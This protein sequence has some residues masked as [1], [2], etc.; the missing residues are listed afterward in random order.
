MAELLLHAED[1]DKQFGITHAVNHVTLDFYK[2]EIHALIGENGSGKSTFTS[3][4]T[5]IYTKEHGQ[6]FLEGQEIHPLNQVDANRK[7]V[8][9]IVQEVGTL[10]GLTVAENI[11]LGKEDDFI[12]N[13]I[14][15]T[16]AMNRKA[17]ELLD[18]YGFTNID[19][20]AVI[21]TYNFEE[22]KLIEIVKSTHFNPKVLVVDETTTAL[23]HEGR[24]ELFKVMKKMRDMGN[25]VIFISHDLEEMLEQSDSISVLRDGVLID[26]VPSEGTTVDDLRKLMV[27]REMSGNFYRTAYG[28]PISKE[29]VLRAEHVS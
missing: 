3:M 4:L 13:G 6:F 7:G 20:T 2:G 28:E 1:I 11:F 14:K 9:I 27:G 26:T 12:S 19:A 5:G 24:V 8:A 18:S 23:G 15:H 29:V 25:C 22:R 10:S 17:Q 21:D 16:N